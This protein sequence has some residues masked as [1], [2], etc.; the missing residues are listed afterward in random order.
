V[1]FKAVPQL[2]TRPCTRPLFDRVKNNNLADFL[3]FSLRG[4]PYEFFHRFKRRRNLFT[5]LLRRS[6][7]HSFLS[8]KFGEI[9][10]ESGSKS[11]QIL[12][13]TFTCCLFSL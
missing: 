6:L 8:N 11:G 4:F 9:L 1:C 7:Q 5:V 3:L 13:M 12:I 10:M 2:K